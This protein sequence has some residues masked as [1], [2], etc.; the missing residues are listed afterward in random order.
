MGQHRLVAVRLGPL[1][2]RRAYGWLTL[3][4]FAG[5]AAALALLKLQAFLLLVNLG[6]S[7]QS[8]WKT[9]VVEVKADPE[10]VDPSSVADA[11]ETTTEEEP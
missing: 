2:Q 4:C 3:V 1:G 5:A 11:A 10:I 7:F 9:T 6:L 8:L